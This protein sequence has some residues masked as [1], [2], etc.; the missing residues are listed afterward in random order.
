VNFEVFCF[1]ILKIWN[2]QFSSCH[3]GGFTCGEIMLGVLF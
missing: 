2:L 3:F 1:S